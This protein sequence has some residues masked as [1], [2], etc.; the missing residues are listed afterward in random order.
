MP[1]LPDGAAK[2][3]LMTGKARSSSLRSLEAAIPAAINSNKTVEQ[4]T[5]DRRHRRRMNAEV[6]TRTATKTMECAKT[7]EVQVD[8]VAEDLLE[9]AVG[10]TEA[11][12]TLVPCLE[13][14]RSVPTLSLNSSHSD[15]A[16]RMFRKST[17]SSSMKSIETS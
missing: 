3:D 17:A 12:A 8:I 15:L 9:V 16:F 11:V 2:K 6:V 1:R 13:E 14:T 4:L 10:V 5:A 7:M